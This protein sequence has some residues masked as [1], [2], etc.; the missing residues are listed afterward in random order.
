MGP[1]LDKRFLVPR[2]RRSEFGFKSRKAAQ[3]TLSDRKIRKS[4]VN[5]YCLPLMS[6]FLPLIRPSEK[7]DYPIGFTAYPIANV[8]KTVVYTSNWISDRSRSLYDAGGNLEKVMDKQW[9][10]MNSM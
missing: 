8:R 6:T 1:N 2:A 10:H 7:N 9:D 4:V 3:Q 5:R